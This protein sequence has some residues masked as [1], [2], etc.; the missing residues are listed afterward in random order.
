MNSEGHKHID[1]RSSY[2]TT[3]FW[4]GPVSVFKIFGYKPQKLTL[5]KRKS[6][7]LKRKLKKS[8]WRVQKPSISRLFLR[9]EEL[10]S[11]IHVPLLEYV[12]KMICIFFF[13]CPYGNSTQDSKSQ[14][15]KSQERESSDRVFLP[16]LSWNGEKRD[17]FY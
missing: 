11:L 8:V 2:C 4:H 12:S 1:H 9:Q 5:A 14:D 10:K 7:R 13:F 6:T 16:W 15:S 17:L 3:H